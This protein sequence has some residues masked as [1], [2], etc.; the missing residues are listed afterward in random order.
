MIVSP[1]QAH[2]LAYL[3]GDV[4]Q[5][6]RETGRDYLIYQCQISSEYRWG[7]LTE[8]DLETIDPHNDIIIR[9]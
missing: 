1:T 8:D 6:A 7:E 3:I 2:E 9:S 4:S 5:L